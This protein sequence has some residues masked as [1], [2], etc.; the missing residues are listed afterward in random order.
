MRCSLSEKT[1]KSS[2]SVKL[3]LQLL[4]LGLPHPLT[5][6]RVCPPLFVPGGGAHSL[7]GEGVEGGGAIPWEHTVH[8]G[9]LG[10]YVPYFVGDTKRTQQFDK[11]QGAV[12]SL[13][14][15]W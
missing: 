10:T 6:R 4:E 7:A 8:C 14:E 1:P 11:T 2:Q 3:F 15:H 5:R 9:T 13:P 12:V